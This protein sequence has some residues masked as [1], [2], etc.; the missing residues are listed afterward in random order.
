[1]MLRTTAKAPDAITCSTTERQAMKTNVSSMAAC[2]L[3]LAPW[4][5]HATPKASSG[6]ASTKASQA[7]LMRVYRAAEKRRICRSTSGAFVEMTQGN[8]HRAHSNGA[9]PL[10]GVL[11]KQL[12]RHASPQPT[13]KGGTAR[14]RWVP[15][16]D[17]ARGAELIVGGKTWQA[18]QRRVGSVRLWY[19][20]N[21]SKN[22][23]WM[24]STQSHKGAM[25]WQGTKL[26]SLADTMDEIVGQSA[27]KQP[28]ARFRLTIAK[29]ASKRRTLWRRLPK[30]LDPGIAQAL[31]RVSSAYHVRRQK[32]A[33]PGR[34]KW[35]SFRRYGAG[36]AVGRYGGAFR[37]VTIHKK[38]WFVM[39]QD[40]H[41]GHIAYLHHRKSGAFYKADF[42]RRG[43]ARVLEI[44]GP[45]RLAPR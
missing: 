9:L 35:H 36:Y 6:S 14:V 16:P 31:Y 29:D 19:A 38:R 5:S 8:P 42:D 25:R 26:R 3:L 40:H 13:T 22:D 39:I 7:R 43:G 30:G 1:M 27:G 20:Y 10:P 2:L 18:I 37:L 4:V 34:G 17:K 15:L 11:L 32:R 21:A 23:L 28:K 24:L 12:H 45:Y 33:R 44:A 41:K